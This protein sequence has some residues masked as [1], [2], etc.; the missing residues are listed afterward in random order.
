MVQT[1]FSWKKLWLFTGP[2]FLMSIAYIDPGNL[3]SDLQAGAVA[4]YQVYAASSLL[5]CSL[6]GSFGGRQLLDC[7]C[8]FVPDMAQPHYCQLL[9][10]RLGVVTGL[11]LAQM[12]RRQYS[13]PIRYTLWVMMEI[14]II[15]SDIQVTMVPL[16]CSS[17]TLQGG[18]RLCH[19]H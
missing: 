6:D 8:R 7:F 1:R 13:R 3:E 11:N 4:G 9:S 12:C 16:C 17:H 19:R 15:A 5:T 2:G 10:V 14:A 18:F